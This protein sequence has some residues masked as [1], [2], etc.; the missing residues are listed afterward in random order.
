MAALVSTPR[1]VT[2]ADRKRGEELAAAAAE[3]DDVA[4]AGEDRQ[5]GLE[6]FRDAV[7]RAAKGIF[8][9]DVLVI[10]RRLAWWR[11]GTGGAGGHGLSRA[12]VGGLA[13][14]HFHRALE[15]DDLRAQLG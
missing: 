14:Q 2:P 5:V 6:L 4:R 9:A 15:N 3:I 8:E 11:G 10:V 7:V 13:L 1:A 12:R